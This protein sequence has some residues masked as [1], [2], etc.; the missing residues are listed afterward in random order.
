MTESAHKAVF[1]SYAREDSGAA[2]RIAEALAEVGI[3]AWLD[4]SELRGGDAWDEKIRRQIKECALFVA[5]ISAN[6]QVRGEGYFRLEWHLAEQRSHLFAKGR[7]FIVPVSID[8]TSDRDALVP[9]AFLSVHWMQ[10]TEDIGA[11]HLAQRIENLLEGGMI[12]APAQEAAPPPPAKSVAVLAF[13]NLSNDPENE[14]FSDG[15]SEELLNVLAKVPGLKVAARSSAFYFKGKRVPVP[16]IAQKLGVANLVEG[17]VRRVGSRLRITAQLTSAADGFTIWSDSFDREL[18]D[19]F[20]VQDEIAAL[21]AGK[22]RVSF[23]ESARV[24]KPINPEAHRLNLQGRHYWNLHLG[25]EEGYIKAEAAFNKALE[26]DPEFAGPYAGLAEVRVMR[27]NY[28]HWRGITDTAD[29]IERS[30]SAARRAIELDPA[31]AEPYA[32]LAYGLMLQG[33]FADSGMQFEKA[34]A[35][36]PNSG[37]T[38]SWQGLLDGGQGMLDSAISEFKRAAEVDPLRFINLQMLVRGLIDARCFDEALKVNLQAA[39]LR[40]DVPML[41]Y[42]DQTQIMMALGRTDEALAA[43]HFIV[44][45]QDLGPRWQADSDAIW[46]LR[47]AGFEKE[48][49]DYAAQLFAKWPPGLYLRGFVLGALGRFE[50]A[51]PFLERTPVLPAIW[52]FWDAMWDPWREDPRFAVLIAKLGRTEDYGVAR[53]TVARMILGRV[54]ST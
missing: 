16:E 31:M 36:N 9:D 12:A 2:L 24:A 14:S 21:I 8:S 39:A 29:D 41:N 18:R 13:A 25:S 26:I 7:P 52:L 54:V 6:T 22:L 45:R 23:A 20:A 5:V 46:V 4:R 37:V 33:K 19:V 38:H 15:I 43:A 28:R 49:A 44:Q 17:S 40:T 32:V 53:E 42:A 3:E 34:L 1:V 50:E 11:L 30:Q 10:C 51:L 27:A 47:K 48:A 35:L